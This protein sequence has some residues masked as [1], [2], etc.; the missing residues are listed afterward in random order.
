MSNGKSIDDNFR[1]AFE[2]DYKT[3]EDEIRG[4]TRQVAWPAIKGKLSDK[5]DFDHEVQVSNLSDAQAQYYVG[6]LLLHMNRL[7]VAESQLQKASALDPKLA[8]TNASLGLLKIR[9]GKNDE[10]LKFLTQAVEGDSTNHLTHYYYAQM[11]QKVDLPDS[12]ADR[13]SHFELMRTHTLKAIELA[14]RFTYSYSLLGYIALVTKEGLP[15]AETAVTKA[16]EYAPGRMDLRLMLAQLMLSNN[17]TQR[18]QSVLTGLKSS[19]TDDVI[20]YQAEQLLTDIQNRRQFEKDY[21]AYEQRRREAEQATT[22]PAVSNNGNDEPPVIRRQ[23]TAP[24][25]AD[26]LVIETAKPQMRIPEGI[27]IEGS[28]INVDCANGLTLRVRLSNA[29]VELHTDT[30]AQLEFVSYVSTV[31]DT[32]ACGVMKP[33]IPVAI[34][35]RHT[36]NTRFLGEPIRVEFVNPN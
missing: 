30:P 11:L 23:N 18:A 32:I 7:D 33:E 17:E 9:Q 2:T 14:P 25:P 3:L 5:L 4:Y 8:A 6:D 20:R 28:L 24:A 36:A 27:R 35:Y 12:A 34:V 16:I 15:E 31:K 29:T 22:P 19:T 10:A 21:Q 1:E 26:D 13:K